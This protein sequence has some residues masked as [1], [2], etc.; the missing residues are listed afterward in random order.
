MT[1]NNKSKIL[2][3]DDDEPVRS[4][5]SE[6]FK[7]E[8]F[9]VE[10]AVDG[11]EGMDM[12]TKNPPNVIFT[13][14]VMPRM[15]GF[16]LKEALAKNVSTASIPVVVSSHLGREEDRERAMQLGVKDF[17]VRNMVTPKEAVE[18][19]RKV[20]GS[21]EY[22]VKINTTELDAAQLAKDI[23]LKENYHCSYCGS[24]LILVLSV[25]DISTHEFKTKIIC[26]N[27]GRA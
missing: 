23:H 25:S 16:M 19:V 4:L 22:R 21:G 5:Y 13:G 8:G 20:L 18:R 6:I 17:I 24:D 2:I 26:P 27:C 1:D 3:I 14:I 9:E 15:D 12:A 11:V 10:E 7:K